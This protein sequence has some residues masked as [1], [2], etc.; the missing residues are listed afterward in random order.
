MKVILFTLGLIICNK[1][2]AQ[3]EMLSFQIQKIIKDAPNDFQNIR[4]AIREINKPND[5]VFFAL[6]NIEGTLRNEVNKSYDKPGFGTFTSTIDS[7]TTKEAKRIIQ[8]WKKRLRDVLG[9][10]YKVKS[11]EETYGKYLG[12]AKGYEFLG[13][14]I[15]IILCYSYLN[16]ADMSHIYLMISRTE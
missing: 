10:S 14:K 12:G 15:R 3:S 4:G 6:I 2:W 11:F 5:T 7:S 9:N 1:S 13:D 8:N 16:M